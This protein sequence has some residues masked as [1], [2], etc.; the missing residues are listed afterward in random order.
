M[1]VNAQNPLETFPSNL[2]VDGGVANLL[3]T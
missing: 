1:A 2:P 3:Q